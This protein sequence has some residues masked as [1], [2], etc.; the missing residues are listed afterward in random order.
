MKNFNVVIAKNSLNMNLAVKSGNSF[1][2]S[3]R[4]LE[5]NNTLVYCTVDNKGFIKIGNFNRVLTPKQIVFFEN[6][7]DSLVTIEFEKTV[8]GSKIVSSYT[9]YKEDVFL[10]VENSFGEL[11]ELYMSEYITYKEE[12]QSNYFVLTAYVDG[13]QQSEEKTTEI[14]RELK[15]Q[16]FEGFGDVGSHNMVGINEDIYYFSSDY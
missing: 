3:F 6:A 5:V 9:N 2:L 10:R 14:I 7:I 11:I 13:V 1:C 4:T 15:S 12:T 8:L 16:N